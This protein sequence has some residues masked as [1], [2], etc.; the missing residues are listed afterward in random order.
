MPSSAT[1]SVS[2][3]HGRPAVARATKSSAAA[4][5]AAAAGWRG[6]HGRRGGGGGGGGLRMA[7]SETL[8]VTL[9]KPM[10]IVLE[11]NVGGFGG[12][13]VKEI[14]AGGSAEVRLF[15]LVVH[16]ALFVAEDGDGGGRS[17]GD[18]D[19]GSSAER[20][21]V[22]CHLLKSDCHYTD[23][24]SRMSDGIFRCLSQLTSGRTREDEPEIPCPLSASNNT[25]YIEWMLCLCRLRIG[26]AC[27]GE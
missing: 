3:F 20:F 2:A 1:A 18:G 9:K 17:G 6:V 12:M 7:E 19:G 26:S 13:R 23:T 5:R 27:C 24:G 10:G 11:E 4:I 21:V 16:A 22:L 25:R 8:E 15:S 14:A